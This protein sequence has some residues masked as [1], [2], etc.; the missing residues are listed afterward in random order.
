[1]GQGS[2]KST[3][4]PSPEELA[5]RLTNIFVEKCFTPLE[6]YCFKQTFKFLA[7]D[8][9]G[10]KYW[11]E[12]TLIEFLELPDALGS[13]A[14]MYYLCGY[15]GAF[16]FSS[17]APAILTGEAL[18]RIVCLMTGRHW[19]VLRRRKEN[20]IREIWRGCAVIDR[21]A[22]AAARKTDPPEGTN[23]EAAPG[24]KDQSKTAG[25]ST[26]KRDGE[27]EEYD[28]DELAYHTFELLD[29]L[30]VFKQGERFDAQHAMIPSDD[31][32]KLLELL[33]LIAPLG[34]QENVSLYTTQLDEKRLEGLRA[35]A[36][37]ILASFGVE[38]KP[39]IGYKSFDAVVSNTLPHL[40]DSLGPL[41]EHFLFPKDFDLHKR[42][43]STPEE[44]PLSPSPETPEIEAASQ[45]GPAHIPAPEP[46]L[47]VEGDILDPNLVSQL[48]FIF[49]DKSIFHRLRPLYLGHNHGYS[50][51]SFEK[52]V[53]KWQ[54]PSILLVSGTLLSPTT[55]QSNARTFLDDLPH[56][57]LSSS[58]TS[59]TSPPI[60]SPAII[61]AQDTKR[62]IY[63]AYIPVPWKATDRTAFG[64]DETTLFQLSPFHDVFPASSVSQNYI[65][66]NKPPST[67]P[68]LGF[69]SL[70]PTYSSMTN[71][72]QSS[73]GPTRRASVTTYSAS[74][75][76]YSSGSFSGGS[77]SGPSSPGRNR[78]SSLIGDE[79]I[80]LGPIS[81]HIDDGLEFGVF[82]HLA[83]GGGSFQHSKLPSSARSS[84]GGNWQDRFEI[85]AIEVWGVGD[86][87]VA[88]ER[89]RARLWEEREAERS[90]KVKLGMK[91][92]EADRELLKTAGLVRDEGRIGQ[93]T[94]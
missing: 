35:V 40:F 33:L 54:A 39:G 2:S 28:E 94:G 29:A 76:E 62:I 18:L 26:T 85:D 36:N 5:L 6:L 87:N 86:A 74:D 71:S 23:S 92:V 30:E 83:S 10:L 68:G 67:Y 51:G 14:V 81:L 19:R 44:S 66:F 41:F 1:M 58:V 8:Q 90:R 50:M 46:L 60:Q 16:P 80:P 91:D 57:R 12:S 17:Y 37:C 70:L 69:G 65:Y 4:P 20:W 53:F 7:E 48:S 79:H 32:L 89:R 13:G 82:T 27:L 55:K 49:S 61:H 22:S 3:E 93:S 63:G 78:R 42:K 77:F 11:S 31:F 34:P 84:N 64:T 52:S 25:A 47:P 59:L 72:Q 45:V 75:M 43:D 88:E 9:S 38:Q 73:S 15:L 24:T 56:R 21:K